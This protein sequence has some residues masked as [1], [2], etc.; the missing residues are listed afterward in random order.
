MTQPFPGWMTCSSHYQTSGVTAGRGQC[1]E[2]VQQH[3]DQR[4]QFCRE[5]SE[6]IIPSR[7]PGD[8]PASRHLHQSCQDWLPGT[9]LSAFRSLCILT[10]QHLVLAG[11]C[12][13]AGGAAV[14]NRVLQRPLAS[15]HKVHTQALSASF[16][17][18][19]H[20]S[21]VLSCCQVQ[22]CLCKLI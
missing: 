5:I 22:L 11:C 6:V 4:E 12:L 19:S 7:G 15:G 14:L 8:R 2:K 16:L 20:L 1:P 17:L 10:L 9:L 21:Q 13:Q 18:V 3:R